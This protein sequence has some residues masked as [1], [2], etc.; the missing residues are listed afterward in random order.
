MAKCTLSR[1]RE[2]S[3][4]MMDSTK[5][6][7]MN[8]VTSMAEIIELQ[9][10]GY[11]YTQ[12]L[13][14]TPVRGWDCRSGNGYAW[15]LLNYNMP[16]INHPLY[17]VY[18]CHM[19]GTPLTAMIQRFANM[20][21]SAIDTCKNNKTC[22]TTTMTRNG[23]PEYVT[24]GADSWCVNP[25]PFV[26]VTDTLIGDTYL[27]LLK[28]NARFGSTNVRV[29][30]FYGCQNHMA[31]FRLDLTGD[32]NMRATRWVALRCPIDYTEV[33]QKRIKTIANAI[34]QCGKDSTCLTRQMSC[35]FYSASSSACYDYSIPRVPIQTIQSSAAL[36]SH[37]TM[38]S[39]TISVELKRVHPCSNGFTWV[40]FI[41][42]HSGQ[43]SRA[44]ALY[45]CRQ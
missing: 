20:T 22:E 31:W 23:C 7:N 3:M 40:E 8:A 21:A 28:F 24:A 41:V 25:N 32:N 30:Q 27:S 2:Y 9:W 43:S 4:C 10:R 36:V 39:G 15:F 37:T 44:W 42:K 16:N 13:K 17:V 5:I 34:R 26:N 14:L 35:S 6:A 12:Q 18:E 33:L 38:T 29:S 45:Y 1:G 19:S 11:E